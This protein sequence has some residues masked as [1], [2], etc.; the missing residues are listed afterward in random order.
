MAETDPMTIN[1]RRKYIYRIWGRYCD[2]TKQEKGY[3]LDEVEE[4]TGMHRK[5]IIRVLNGRLSRKPR[6]RERGKS[7]GAMAGDAARLIAKSLDYPC[8]ERLKNNLVWMAEQLHRFG[9]LTLT[10]ELR[11]KLETM[12]VSTIKHL[13]CTTKTQV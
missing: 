9:E 5:S 4:V 2:G 3:L 11:G 8:A 7:Y 10:D 12:S 13:V 6:S 1:E